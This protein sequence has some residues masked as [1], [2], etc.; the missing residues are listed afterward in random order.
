MRCMSALVWHKLLI[1][2][3]LPTLISGC[4]VPVTTPSASPERQPTAA[5]QAQRPAKLLGA[6]RRA[7]AAVGRAWERAD[8]LL[9]EACHI[10]IN[11]VLQLAM[12]LWLVSGLAWLVA[13]AVALRAL[14]SGCAAGGACINPAA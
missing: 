8:G 3:L 11:D 10:L 2:V 12:G 7:A 9:R 5:Q 1:A 4:T 13:K 6:L 14:E